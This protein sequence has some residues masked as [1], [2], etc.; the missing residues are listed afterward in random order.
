MRVYARRP[1]NLPLESGS[2]AYT[3]SYRVELERQR[4]FHRGI[5]LWSRLVIMF[6]SY[7]LFY[8]GFAMAHPEVGRG[9][10]AVIAACLIVLGIAAVPLNL[11]LSRKYQRQMDE[12]DLLPKTR[13]TP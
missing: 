4:D 10:A 2:S 5:W 12:L 8:L 1:D 13:N 7:M 3:D 9:F 11:R 6:P